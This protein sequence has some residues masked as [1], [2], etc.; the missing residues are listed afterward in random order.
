[1][2]Q[3]QWY[4]PMKSHNNPFGTFLPQPNKKTTMMVNRNILNVLSN[5][6]QLRPISMR[7]NISISFLKASQY[8]ETFCMVFSLQ[9]FKKCHLLQHGPEYYSRQRYMFPSFKLLCRATVI[10]DSNVWKILNSHTAN[11][12]IIT[13]QSSCV[14]ARGI[15]PAA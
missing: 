1:M 5:P 12:N 14:N 6:S 7:D 10:L 3:F 15:P 8:L 2:S 11:L 9:N 13:R 4:H